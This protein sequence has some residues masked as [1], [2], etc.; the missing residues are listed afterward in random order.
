MSGSNIDKEVEVPLVA[1]DYA[2]M[3]DRSRKNASDQEDEYQ[4]KILAGRDQ[5]SRCYASIAIPQKGVDP[6]EY[7]TRRVIRFTEF[8]G[9]K[10]W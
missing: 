10:R 6:E 7:A 4:V 5:M 2:F 1:F 9:T 3:S 8:L